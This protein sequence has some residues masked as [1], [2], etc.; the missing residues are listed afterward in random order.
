[1]PSHYSDCYELEERKQRQTFFENVWEHLDM[2]KTQ[3]PILVRYRDLDM[4]ICR[5]TDVS[6]ELKRLLIR[7]ID[8]RRLERMGELLR[9]KFAKDFEG[10]DPINYILDKGLS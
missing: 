7:F 1:M 4:E 8:V 6:E 3:D 10:K 5:S 2:M 9:I